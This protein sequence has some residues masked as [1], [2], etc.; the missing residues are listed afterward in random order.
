MGFLDHLREFSGRALRTAKD[1]ISWWIT[2][3]VAQ[4]PQMFCP[5]RQF[6]S[7]PADP[8]TAGRP[9]QVA[10]AGSV[11]LQP[12][13]AAREEMTPVSA[14]EGTASLTNFVWDLGLDLPVEIAPVSAVQSSAI[15][16]ILETS[17]DMDNIAAAAGM[18][19]EIEWPHEDNVLAVF[20]RLKSHFHA[21]FDPTRKILP[22]AQARA[23]A[24][25]KAMCH[26]NV[27]QHMKNE[28]CFYSDGHICII[29]YPDSG[30]YYMIPD[31]GF[32]AVSFAVDI[33][34]V[35]LDMASIPLHDRMWIAHMLTYRLYN[36]A[37]DSNSDFKSVIGFIGTCL[38]SKAPT[39][40]V[41]DCMLLAGMLMG[42]KVNRRHLAQLDKR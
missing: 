26:L 40:L 6:R 34:S 11:P 9:E 21:C 29:S 4:L 30:I 33:C 7:M 31:Q 36:G 24:C 32:L 1:L 42:G 3:F 22:L 13:P 18:L 16:W 2:P 23:I 27:E 15:Q 5:A 8:E 10:S 38:D 12:I 19:P 17:T 39:R 35:K 14:R 25:L 20:N 28:F 41:A 37:N